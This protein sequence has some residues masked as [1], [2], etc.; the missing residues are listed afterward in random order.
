M[1]ARSKNQVSADNDVR[2]VNAINVLE[3]LA[4]AAEL[5]PALPGFTRA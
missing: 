1:L 3:R 4:R 2:S 5:T